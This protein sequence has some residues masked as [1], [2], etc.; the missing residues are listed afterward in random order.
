M[1][2]D[3]N[4][5]LTHPF[6]KLTAGGKEIAAS[7][8]D[9]M[10]T[11]SRA[12]PSAYAEFS[13]P[14]RDSLLNG[15]FKK[16]DDIKIEW[17]YLDPPQGLPASAAIFTGK[18]ATVEESA[19]IKITAYDPLTTANKKTFAREF[20][21]ETPATIITS[22]C[23]ELGIAA[24]NLPS[25]PP[26]DRIALHGHNLSRAIAEIEAAA[27]RNGR[28]L[29]GFAHFIDRGG[30]LQ[31]GGRDAAVNPPPA[32]PVVLT[33]GMIHAARIPSA[34]SSGRVR[35]IALPWLAH[36]TKVKITEPQILKADAEY[37][38]SGITYRQ[39]GSSLWMEIS[40]DA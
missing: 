33:G 20:R 27:R 34:G 24:G 7:M 26:M 18:A 11:A 23:G 28:P 12:V 2:T 30:K 8:G 5:T 10:V 4:I 15:I 40:I 22:L 17:G 14:N 21:K 29:D 32:A 39:S 36:S 25:L 35:T 6:V 38:A 1:T 19:T 9:C 37:Y 31:W 3:K 13:V 16:D